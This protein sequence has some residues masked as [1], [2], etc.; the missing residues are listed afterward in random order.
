MVPSGDC[1]QSTVSDLANS[2][3]IVATLIVLLLAGLTVLR[4]TEA[5]ADPSADTR[6]VVIIASGWQSSSDSKQFF[7]DW[8][9]YVDELAKLSYPGISRPVQVRQFSYAGFGRPY[10]SCDTDNPLQ[11]NVTALQGQIDEYRREFPQARLMIVGH[12]LG[13]AVAAAWLAES[14]D[15]DLV[16]VVT[17]DSPVRGLTW[18]QTDQDVFHSAGAW[19]VRKLFC[20]S[21]V[22]RYLNPNSAEVK[23]MAKAAGKDNFYSGAS[24]DDRLILASSALLASR[25]EHQA[26]FRSGDHSC[27]AL[28]AISQ[29]VS[30]RPAEAPADLGACWLQSHGTVLEDPAALSWVSKLAAQTLKAAAP[31]AKESTKLPSPIATPTAV[32]DTPTAPPNASQGELERIF[33]GLAAA[34]LTVVETANA[35]T[36]A[37]ALFCVQKTTTLPTYAG[38]GVALLPGWPPA[39][40]VAP[41]VVF[42]RFS[43]GTW[44]FVTTYSS[45]PDQ[46]WQLPGDSITCPVDGL[47]VR[48]GPSQATSAVTIL[49]R[50][51]AVR[52]EEF[53]LEA[54][55]F[56]GTEAVGRGWFRISSP[57]SGWVSSSFISSRLTAC[58]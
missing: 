47:N 58:P 13:G 8:G 31:P 11:A 38:R 10:K 54:R 48:A 25:A 50:G 57:N 27:E 5:R 51:T 2:R 37:G 56:Y 22:P 6:L 49:K 29:I 15:T 30:P 28:L 12:S 21:E 18:A 14:S 20:N 26:T 16:T 43:D 41:T 7:A 40:G 1:G 45:S 55:G 4:P 32:L 19:A 42:G 3:R 52:V 24:L 44:G 33:A 46:T 35:Q 34:R 53:V 17:L 39:Q 23:A 9:T 36:C